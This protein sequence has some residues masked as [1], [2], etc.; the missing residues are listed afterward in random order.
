MTDITIEQGR[1][2]A[3]QL[4]QLTDKQITDAFRAANYSPDEVELLKVGFKE[5]V[6]ELDMAT[7]QVTAGN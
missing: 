4:K 2:L 6:K 5:R 7:R 3:E 1:W